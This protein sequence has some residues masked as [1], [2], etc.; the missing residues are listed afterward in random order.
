MPSLLSGRSTSGQ[1][2]SK[3][4]LK[5]YVPEPQIGKIALNQRTEV[6]V[7]AYPER[8]FPARVSKIASQAEFTPK[9]VETKE[10]RSVG[11]SGVQRVKQR[12]GFHNIAA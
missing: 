4:Y 1:Q 8:V 9:N 10:V 5:I 2:C 7:D 6:R 11:N 3:L 12:A